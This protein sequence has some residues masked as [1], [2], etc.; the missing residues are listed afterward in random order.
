[1]NQWSYTNPQ[2]TPQQNQYAQHAKQYQNKANHAQY[3]SS[4]YL[5]QQNGYNQHPN[6]QL[7]PTQNYFTGSRST[8][9]LS[10]V[11]SNNLNGMK[12]ANST[13][14]FNGGYPNNG[15]YNS[16]NSSVP[17]P[18]PQPSGNLMYTQ[19]SPQSMKKHNKHKKISHQHRKHKVLCEC[20]YVY[21]AHA[22]MRNIGASKFEWISR[23][24]PSIE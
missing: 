23:Q 2:V 16:S 5:H 17:P 12:M 13:G 4:H 7:Q 11:P 24:I 8:G 3:G 6:G 14:N 19:S 18:P 20:F 15:S 10:Q 22:N 9:N 21:N 1:M